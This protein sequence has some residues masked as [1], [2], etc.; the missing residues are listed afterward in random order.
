MVGTM[1]GMAIAARFRDNPREAAATAF[2]QTV[3]Q[4]TTAAEQTRHTLPGTGY[5]PAK[6]PS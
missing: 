1:P 3:T 4:F 6:R 5:D 2:I